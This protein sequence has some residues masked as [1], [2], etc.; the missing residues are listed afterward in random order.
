MPA[1]VTDPERPIVLVAPGKGGPRLV[2]LNWA[3]EKSG[4]VAGELLSNARS[5]VLDLQSRAADPAADDAALRRLALSCLRYTPLVAPWD[6]E[7]GADG[8]FLD[9]AGCA[10]LFGGEAGLLSDLA[11][12]LRRFGLRPR[13]AIADTPGAAWAIARYGKAESMIVPSNGTGSALQDLPLAALRLPEET[14]VLLRRLGFRRIGELIHRPRAPLA[15]RFGAQFLNRLDQALGRAPE[16][17]SPLAPPPVYRAQAM[18]VEAIT[19]QAHVVEAA[20]RLLR[21][22]AES[23]ARDGVGARKLRLLLFRMDGEVLSLTIG[24]AAPS[25]DAQHIASL[26][27]LRLDR[28]PGG[29]EADFGFEAA[30]IHVLTAECMPERQTL[31]PVAGD[32]TDLA[33]LARLIDRLEQR[34]GAGAVRRIHPRQ[35][36]IPER[37]VLLRRA[38]DGLPAEWAIDVPCNARPLLLLT[39]PEAA[40]VMALIPEGPP[41]HF[42]WRGVLHQVAQAEGP[43]RIAGEWWLRADNDV[44]RDYY[45]VED[46]AGRRFWLYRAGL[47][48]RGG[49]TPQWFVHGVFP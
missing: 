24:L 42:R 2:A 26:I 43:E 35:S 37:A 34:L 17:L 41:R 7:N 9:I 3:A 20:T 38:A 4:L 22:L 5:K 46:A 15:S 23:L 21:D 29:L 18:F 47:Y 40:E 28:L 19:T 1:D 45:I 31:L 14:R 10:H 25:R 13:L 48:D 33:G 16:P 49:A 27:A 30:G 12:R 39:R 8:L 6:E 36:H 32:I 11:G 44:E